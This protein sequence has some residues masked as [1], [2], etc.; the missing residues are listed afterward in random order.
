MKKTF[1]A[2]AA[3]A[4]ALSAF[5][6]EQPKPPAGTPLDVP[7]EKLVRPTLPVCEG[8]KITKTEYQGEKLPLGLTATVIR[9]DSPRRWSGFGIVARR[10]SSCAAKRWRSRTR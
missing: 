5:A 2:L 10:R 3:L 7:T 4:L 1:I 9:T 6:Q 8:M